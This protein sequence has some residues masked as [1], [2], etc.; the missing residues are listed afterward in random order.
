M[1]NTKPLQLALGLLFACSAC[2]TRAVRSDGTY[3]Y[4]DT[5]AKNVKAG[6]DPA[7]VRVGEFQD[8]R[9]QVIGLVEAHT[10]GTQDKELEMKEKLTLELRGQ[11]AEMNADGITD[12]QTQWYDHDGT[13]LHAVAKAYRVRKRP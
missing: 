1:S 4:F 13:A 5:S 11:A 10:L 7:S 12:I 9:H 3:I 6:R 2:A 8:N